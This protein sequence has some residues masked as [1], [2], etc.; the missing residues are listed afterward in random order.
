MSQQRFSVVYESVSAHCC[1]SSTVVDNHKLDQFQ[2]PE[3]VCEC[4]ED[5]AA[6]RICAALNVYSPSG[7]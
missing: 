2:K 5:S 3:T 4:F 1:F 6:E 7:D